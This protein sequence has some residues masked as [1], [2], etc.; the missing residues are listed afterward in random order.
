[1]ATSLVI[2]TGFGCG[3]RVGGAMGAMQSVIVTGFG[4]GSPNCTTIL[5]LMV[6]IGGDMSILYIRLSAKS[7]LLEAVNP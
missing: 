7:G 4:S 2:A 3:S 1:M 5:A 6:I